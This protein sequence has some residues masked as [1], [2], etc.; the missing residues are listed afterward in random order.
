MLK[1]RLLN[2]IHRELRAQS[3]E[4]F[5]SC[6]QQIEQLVN[7]GVQRMRLNKADE[8]AGHFVQAEQNLKA[9]IRYLGEYAR[10]A[11]FFR[12]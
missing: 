6:T 11:G 5:P 2:L 1:P 7:N 9:L 4:L 3:L 8:H 10:E 12:N